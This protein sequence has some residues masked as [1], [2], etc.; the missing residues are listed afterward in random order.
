MLLYKY[1]CVFKLSLQSYPTL[2]DPKDC[3]P[4]GPSDHGILQARVLG[5]V[6]IP[7]SRALPD[8]EIKCMSLTSSALTS[9]FFTTSATWLVL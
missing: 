6:A 7:F 9:G 5:C 2:C 1:M 3:G 8:P 4:L